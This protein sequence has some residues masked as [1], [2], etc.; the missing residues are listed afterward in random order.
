MGQ[1]FAEQYPKVAARLKLTE[2]ET[3]DPYVE[4]LLEGVSF[5]TARTQLKIDAE[6]PR[7]VRRI[8]EVVYPQF[9]YPVPSST[10]VKFHPSDNHTTN[11]VNKLKRGHV[12]ETLPI[13]LPTETL[14]CQYSV[15]QDTEL[16]PITLESSIYTNSLD[17]LPKLD[18]ANKNKSFNHQSALRLNFSV[19]S[20]GR[21][22]EL[23]PEELV[24][25]LGSDLPIS[26]QLLY[27]LMSTCSKVVCHS[28]EDARKWHYSL[29]DLPV[30]KGFDKEEALIFNLDKTIH[31]LRV[32]QEYIQL[33]EKFLFISQSGIKK[34]L[35]KAEVNGDIARSS[36]QI[37]KVMADKGVNKRVVSY[38]KRWFSV[39]FLFDKF[40]PDLQ[41]LIKENMLSI[42]TTPVV[43]LFKK[44]SVRFPINIENTE[45]HVVVDRVQPLNFEVHSVE[46]VKGFDKYN[47]QQIIFTPIYQAKDHGLFIDQ[48]RTNAFFSLRREERTPSTTIKLQGGRTSYLGSEVFLSL[49]SLNKTMFD[50]D[51]EYLAVDTWC[52]N[53]DLP[54]ILTRSSESDFLIDST[55]PIKAANI[56]SAVSKPIEAVNEDQTLWAL[57]NQLNLS[58]TSLTA[59]SEKNSTLLLKELL[60]AFPHD[61]NKFYQTEIS[62]IK[63]LSVTPTT[64]IIRHK[65]AGGLI[66]GIAVVITFDESLLGGIH[67]Y[68]FGSV[69]KHYL[70]RSVSVN[71][72]VDVIIETIQHG[73]IMEWS[74]LKG[75]KSLL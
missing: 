31:S 57:L 68:L 33:P 46:S 6:Y 60:L 5:L 35:E 9:L 17:Y 14:S 13:E 65:G 48:Q 54:L 44:K 2:N 42:N 43:N 22:S 10:I 75:E 21:C 61:N 64:R 24:V 32:I 1:E 28:F 16:T 56:I 67:P 74:G 7:F 34:A 25:Y 69:L 51:I 20:S 11:V 30:H 47:N 63:N 62:S 38:K 29:D 73:K 15:T 45:H 4:R 18:K 37:E 52:T 41:H 71:S 8:L 49:S 27:L 72:Y 66:R 40:I 39:S 70:Q 53:R 58:Y 23:A 36:D 55:L 26:S 50:L 12:L 59:Q 3:P 19:S